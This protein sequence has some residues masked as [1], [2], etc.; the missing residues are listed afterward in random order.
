MYCVVPSQEL[1]VGYL[2]L[3]LGHPI[4]DPSGKA[5][6]WSAIFCCYC[7]TTHC[8]SS[9]LVLKRH[10]WRH[11]LLLHVEICE[12]LPTRRRFRCRIP[13]L[14]VEVHRRLEHLQ[15]DRAAP[16]E[17]HPRRSLGD[18]PQQEQ[19]HNPNR[20]SR[21]CKC[22]TNLAIELPDRFPL[23]ERTNSIQAVRNLPDSSSRCRDSTWCRRLPIA[24]YLLVP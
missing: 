19:D 13:N 7:N 12:L 21:G 2:A 10:C 18:R 15:E 11:A 22:E 6:S 24:E 4:D 5:Q 1:N 17:L 9:C 3:R 14:H 16:R 23:H 8:V 20:I